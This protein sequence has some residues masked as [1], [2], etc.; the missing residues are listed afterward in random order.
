MNSAT[1]IETEEAPKHSRV[2]E[3]LVAAIRAGEFAPGEQLPGERDVAA[4]YGVSYMTARRAI[5]EMVE[6]DLLERR[7]NRG[8]FV[9]AQ[10]SRRLA[11]VT[12]NLIFPLQQSSFSEQ[13]T[14]TA[15]AGIARRGWHSH[16]VQLQS[17]RERAAVR[18]LQSGEPAI[19][20]APHIEAP[21]EAAI[22]AATGTVVLIANRLSDDSVPSIMGDDAQAMRLILERLQTLGHRNIGFIS[23]HPNHPIEQ[24]RYQQ[25]RQACAQFAAPDEIARRYI[26]AFESYVTP[27]VSAAHQIYGAVRAYLEAPA[28]DVTALICAG[29]TMAIS[30]M[31]ACRD[32]GYPVPDKM[33]LVT[34]GDS[35]MMEFTHPAISCV[36]TRLPRHVEIALEQIEAAHSGGA[37]APTVPLV[38]PF[39]IERAT[40]AAPR[41]TKAN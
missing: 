33:S 22:R 12:V 13:F 32:A 27:D 4:R 9:R 26:R 30:A 8:T 35:A 41:E 1:A 38:E 34:I 23:R 28:C 29:D 37:P 40:L 7:P 25:W 36:D 18:A 3:L 39:L 16:L 6:A 17:G 24:L 11:A 31:A 21:L 15:L 10:G 19:I 2:R 5:T 14:Q 20:L